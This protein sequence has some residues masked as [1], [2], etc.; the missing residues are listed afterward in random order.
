MTMM[1]LVTEKVQGKD[2]ESPCHPEPVEGQLK[3]V[4]LSLKKGKMQK[5]KKPPALHPEV[6][7]YISKV[8]TGAKV[9]IILN[10]HLL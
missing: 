3:F 9:I 10:R 5:I 4:T 8:K 1:K 7:T 2:N 6:S